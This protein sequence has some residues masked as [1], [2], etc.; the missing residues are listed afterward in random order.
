[1]PEKEVNTSTHFWIRIAMDIV[2][3]IKKENLSK[4]QI[5]VLSEK[6]RHSKYIGSMKVVPGHTM[7][8]FNRDTLD[9]NNNVIGEYDSVKDAALAVKGSRRKILDCCT[10]KRAVHIKSR[11]RFLF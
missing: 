2:P 11:W 7:F 4:Q 1:M 6:E 5:E 8:S 10:G 9:L 3:D